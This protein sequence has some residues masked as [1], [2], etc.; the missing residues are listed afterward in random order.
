MF[1]FYR[2]DRDNKTFLERM[3]DPYESTKELQA[4]VPAEIQTGS[5]SLD[6]VA[7]RSYKAFWTLK[8]AI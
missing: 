3:G 6:P 8:T 7:F 1:I 4:R 5:P 2:L